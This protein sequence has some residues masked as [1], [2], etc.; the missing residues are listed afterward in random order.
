M[1]VFLASA[2]RDFVKPQGRE[3]KHGSWDN[4][5]WK[6]PQEALCVLRGS[7]RERCNARR[8]SNGLCPDRGHQPPGLCKAALHPRALQALDPI[9]TLN[10]I[11]TM[12]RG[13]TGLA[14]NTCG[15]NG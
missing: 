4:S 3:G 8:W 15:K 13:L 14:Y 1:Q 6:G 5:G 7:R 12:G 2:L 10:G 9:G 11:C